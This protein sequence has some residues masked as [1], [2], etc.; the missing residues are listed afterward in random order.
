MAQWDPEGK[1]EAL[2]MLSQGREE[3]RRGEGGDP[4]PDGGG[5]RAHALSS[6]QALEMGRSWPATL[7]GSS[8]APGTRVLSFRGTQAR[9]NVS[10]PPVVPSTNCL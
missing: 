1:V 5:H 3:G 4:L 2:R 6:L 10:F 7:L 9:Q 8:K